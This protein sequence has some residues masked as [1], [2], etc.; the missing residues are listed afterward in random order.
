[1]PA[2][3]WVIGKSMFSSYHVDRMIPEDVLLS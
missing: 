2:F 3:F 1:M